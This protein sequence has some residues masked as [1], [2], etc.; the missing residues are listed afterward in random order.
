MD[1]K[2]FAFGRMNFILLAI[3]M[4]IVVIGFI[5]MAG[6]GSTDQA[7]NPDIF[8]ARRI[9]VAPLVCL[10]GFVSMIYAVVH[11]SK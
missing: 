6:D 11:K 4:V 9:K 5:L 2:D 7:Y 8:S 1:K 3:S 10:F